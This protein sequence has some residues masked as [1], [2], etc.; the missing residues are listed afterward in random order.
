MYTIGVFG[1]KARI[2]WD[3]VTLPPKFPEKNGMVCDDVYTIGDF[4]RKPRIVC[5]DVYTIGDFAEFRA[6]MYDSVH[7]IGLLPP[8]IRQNAGNFIHYRR[9]FASI[10]GKV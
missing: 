1:R 6:M 8:K 2:V 5:D 10:R 9:L 4:A 3:S 7:T